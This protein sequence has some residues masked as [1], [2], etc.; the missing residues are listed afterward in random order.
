[1]E[2]ITLTAK[3]KIKDETE[4]GKVDAY[5]ASDNNAAVE[6]GYLT[7]KFDAEIPETFK[8]LVK[9]HSE[10]DILKK[11]NEIHKIRLQ[12]AKRIQ[13]V[14]AISDKEMTLAAIVKTSGLSIEEIKLRLGMS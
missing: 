4:K 12:D 3:T 6:K 5:L 7:T 13:L 14:A 11:F 10:D 1:M 9:T 8:E 2:T